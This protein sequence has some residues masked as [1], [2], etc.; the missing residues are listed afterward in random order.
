[1]V[2]DDL[3]KSRSYLQNND[4]KR[5]GGMAQALGCLSSKHEALS[6]NSSNTFKKNKGKSQNVKAF[7]I[8][9][10]YSTVKEI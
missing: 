6:S 9:Q 8:L 3:G 4:S 10:S 5:A 1:V 7:Q 2:Q